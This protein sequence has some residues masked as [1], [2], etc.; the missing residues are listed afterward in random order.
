MNLREYLRLDFAVNLKYL[1]T[2]EY[3]EVCGSNEELHLHHVDRF[4]NLLIDTLREL[5][6]NELNDISEYSKEILLLIRD[7]MISK[8]IRCEYK[9]LCKK[10]HAKIHSIEKHSDEYKENIYNP[11][12]NYFFINIEQILQ[13][14]YKYRFRFLYLCG[15]LNYDNQLIFGSSKKGF[16]YMTEKDFQ[17]VLS[18][19]EREARYTKN[20]FKNMGCF[21]VGNNII[22]IDKKFVYKGFKPNGNINYVRIFNDFLLNL[23]ILSNPIEHNSLGRL[24]NLLNILDDNNINLS[25]TKVCEILE[26]N[27]S[28]T[29]RNM[30][31][32]FD[33]NIIIKI[34]DELFINPAFIY[35]GFLNNDLKDFQQYI[36]D[37]K[38]AQ[39]D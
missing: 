21:S 5:N 32:F 22:T 31:I 11:Y 25:L 26:Y 39:N 28:K 1:L 8:Q 23:Y 36:E 10:C 37:S 2:K 7:K 13:F 18:L 29:N 35:Y 34:N 14:D 20:Y 12:G 33:K 19:S 15:Y 16:N 4:H 6:I 3:C 17:E 24:F 9:T 27:T 30:K 38:S